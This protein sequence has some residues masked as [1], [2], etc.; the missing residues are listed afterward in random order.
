MV[1]TKSR[2]ICGVAESGNAPTSQET[3][4]AEGIPAYLT[5]WVGVPIQEVGS[6]NA[7]TP[8]EKTDPSEDQ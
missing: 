6:W 7:A 2:R 1:S 8:P 3:V 4:A 5:G